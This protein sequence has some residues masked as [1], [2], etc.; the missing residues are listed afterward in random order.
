M[1]AVCCMLYGECRILFAIWRASVSIWFVCYTPSIKPCPGCIQVP[2]QIYECAPP[3]HRYTATRGYVDELHAHRPPITPSE[4]CSSSD[5][6]SQIEKSTPLQHFCLRSLMAGWSVSWLAA[7]WPTCHLQHLELQP[8][9]R[10][11]GRLLPIAPP[12]DLCST[13]S[14]K[15]D[16]LQE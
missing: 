9:N 5:S 12:P 16:K 4:K 7:S 3:I 11:D 2:L 15:Y 10:Q 13:T 8:C 6:K 1:M 14:Y